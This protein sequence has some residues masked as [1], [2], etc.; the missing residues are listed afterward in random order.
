MPSRR[1]GLQFIAIGLVAALTLGKRS[2]CPTMLKQMSALRASLEGFPTRPPAYAS[3][4]RL[5]FCH[6]REL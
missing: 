2:A 4:Y 3:S 1:D 5:P 6:S